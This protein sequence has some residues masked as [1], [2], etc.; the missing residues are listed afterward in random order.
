M[1]TK[2]TT[3]IKDFPK[4]ISVI[5]NAI[6]EKTSVYIDDEIN[7]EH[8]SENDSYR[9][10]TCNTAVGEPVVINKNLLNSIFKFKP[11]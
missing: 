2:N 11:L 3:W 9:V 5:G 10:N 8:L 1:E 6:D 4:R 7:C